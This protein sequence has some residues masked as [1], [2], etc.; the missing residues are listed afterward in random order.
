MDL[1]DLR[2]DYEAEGELEL[3]PDP[4][5]EFERWLGDALAAGISEANAMT[6]ATASAAGRPSARTVLLKCVDEHGFTFFTNYGSRKGRELDETPWAALVFYWP[7]LHRQVIVEGPVTR[8]DVAESDEYFASR[9]LGSRLGVWASPQGQVIVSRRVLEER[10]A[11][12]AARYGLGPVP[13]PEWWGG[14]RLEP[15]SIEF[16]RGRPSRLHDRLRYGRTA[17]GGWERERLSP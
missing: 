14:F 7:P 11:E 8:L 2:E 9:P 1:G 6:L 12:A 3:G 17:D 16:W 5:L 10:L 4:I 13:R 15:E